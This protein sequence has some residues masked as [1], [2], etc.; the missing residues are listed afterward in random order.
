MSAEN[1]GFNYLRNRAALAAGATALSEYTRARSE[2]ISDSEVGIIINAGI[3]ARLGSFIRREREIFAQVDKVSVIGSAA[4]E[5][6]RVIVLELM[7]P[8][9][10]R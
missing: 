8:K 5:G 1:P 9:K 7:S 3:R 6:A 2:I 4:V 10:P